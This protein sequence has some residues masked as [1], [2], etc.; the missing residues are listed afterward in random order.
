M[1]STEPLRFEIE[2]SSIGPPIV[3]WW[4]PAG[5]GPRDFTG[6]T[7]LFAGLDSALS[8]TP[9]RDDPEDTPP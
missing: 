8:C 7:E 2:I 3:G 4:Q 9:V 5:K 1:P 6:W